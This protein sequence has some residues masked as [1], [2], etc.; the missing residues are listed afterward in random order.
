MEPE[1]KDS[2]IKKEDFTGPAYSDEQIARDFKKARTGPWECWR[3]GTKFSQSQRKEF[4]FHNRVTWGGN[5]RCEDA[6]EAYKKY[7]KERY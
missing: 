7:E 3:C 2:Q 4:Y 1:T 5:M 6:F